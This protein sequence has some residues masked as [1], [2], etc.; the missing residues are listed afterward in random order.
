LL[1]PENRAQLTQILQLHVVRGT[2]TAADLVNRTTTLETLSGL[3]IIV[4]GFN[5][6]DVGGVSVVQPD[7]MASNGVM[8]IVDGVILP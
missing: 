1:L 7:V 5:G 3:N 4:D 6:V 2:Y 8:H